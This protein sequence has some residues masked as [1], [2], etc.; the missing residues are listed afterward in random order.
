MGQLEYDNTAF[1][2]FLIAIVAVYLVMDIAPALAPTTRT[3][4]LEPHQYLFV[5]EA[6]CCRATG[7]ANV[8]P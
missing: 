6:M 4:S 5:L 8:S 2:Y 3:E 7:S 1:Y